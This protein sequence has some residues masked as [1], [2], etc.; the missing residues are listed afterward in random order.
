MKEISLST[1][2]EPTHP[3][4]EKASQN[5]QEES[6]LFQEHNSLLKNILMMMMVIITTLM[7]QIRIANNHFITLFCLRMAGI[8]AGEDPALDSLWHAEGG[9]VFAVTAHKV[10][11][12]CPASQRFLTSSPGIVC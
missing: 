8:L 10:T 9:F 2:R 12:T 11:I 5:Q 7:W 6:Y 4:L 1:R 3:T